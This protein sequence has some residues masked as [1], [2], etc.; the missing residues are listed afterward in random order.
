MCTTY[1]DSTNSSLSWQRKT[2]RDEGVIE[3]YSNKYMES[4]QMDESI[5][6]PI[7]EIQLPSLRP[8][9]PTIP[10]CFCNNM[11][12]FTRIFLPAILTCV[13]GAHSWKLDKSCPTL[14]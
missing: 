11:K 1:T 5:Y 10:T 6:D 2:P 9:E 3:N 14:G 8:E 7:I 4:A 12:L 13:T